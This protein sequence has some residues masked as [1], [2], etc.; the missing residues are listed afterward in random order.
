MANNCQSE[1]EKVEARLAEWRKEYELIRA[2]YEV[3]RH[4]S[5]INKRD[6]LLEK[7]EKAERWLAIQSLT[8]KADIEMMEANRQQ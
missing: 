4:F 1:I 7:I 2:T 8:P 3:S 6:A 5:L